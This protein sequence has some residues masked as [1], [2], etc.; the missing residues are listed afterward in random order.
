MWEGYRR[1]CKAKGW[2]SGRFNGA[3]KGVGEA[4]IHAR[5][6]THNVANRAPW[7]ITLGATRVN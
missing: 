3:D 7:G 6:D 2:W 5:T 1:A 4:L